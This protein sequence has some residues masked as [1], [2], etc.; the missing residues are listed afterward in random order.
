[1]PFSLVSGTRPQQAI[2]AASAI[3]AVVIFI[4]HISI[5]RG[6]SSC[7]DQSFSADIVATGASGQA[8]DKGELHVRGDKVRIVAPGNA[9]DFF[10]IDLAVETTYLVRPTLRAFMDAKQSSRLTQLLVPVDSTDPCAQWQRMAKIAG[11]AENG[12][13][14]CEGLG[15]AMRDGRAEIIYRA[16]SPLGRVSLVWIDAKLGFLSR[17]R[18]ED[19]TGFELKD[20]KQGPQGDNLFEVPEGYGKFDPKQLIERIKQSDVWVEPP[21]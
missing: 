13:W 16:I 6:Q 9:K 20:V 12:A 2:V 8:T 15:E 10:V 21:K 4:G 1:M 17:L 19:G 18:D 11:A 5:A 3:F 14:R 7:A